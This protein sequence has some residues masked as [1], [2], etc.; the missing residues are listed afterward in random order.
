LGITWLPELSMASMK[1][2]NLR[3]GPLLSIILYFILP[4][5]VAKISKLAIYHDASQFQRLRG[6]FKNLQPIR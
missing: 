3:S 2:R 6:K 5:S 4:A 1:P